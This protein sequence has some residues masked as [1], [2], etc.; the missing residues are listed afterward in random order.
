[1]A[2]IRTIKPEFW[3]SEQIVKCSRDS[4]LL[5]V[6]MWN[7]CDDAG[8]HPASLMRLKMEVFPGDTVDTSELGGWIEELIQHELLNEY[9]VDG[10][11]FWQIT[12]WAK[13]QR[14][15]QPNCRHP[16]PD[17]TVSASRKR[18]GGKQRQLVYR[19]LVE[20]DGEDCSKCGATEHLAVDHKVP[21]SQGGSNELNNLQLL[22]GRCNSE[23]SA[24]VPGS[25]SQ[26][27][28]REPEGYAPPEGKG[29]EEGEG[30]PP[31]PSQEITQ[32][33]NATFGLKC[34]LTA[35][36]RQQLKVRWGEATW[37]DSWQS[38]LERAGPSRFLNG[39]NERGWKIDLEFFLKP[40]SVTKIIEGK[41]DNRTGTSPQRLT[42]AQQREQ[43]NADAFQAV[44]GDGERTDETLFDEESGPVHPTPA[45]Y[46]GEGT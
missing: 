14:I 32:Q 6:G 29:R 5:F 13:H 44:F 26:G 11:C 10:K 36:R 35:K 21:F 20:R 23:K 46:L 18:L 37:R 39:D 33:F 8:I 4:R 9:E 15:D 42:A 43:S 1:M 38:A 24:T 3:T 40:D 22:C 41:Y 19:K 27:T 25:D 16:K 7:F 28:R 34:Q 17:G 2:R 45:G 12:G 31:C 30:V